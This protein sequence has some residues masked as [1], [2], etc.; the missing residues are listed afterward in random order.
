[1]VVGLKPDN[2]NGNVGL[3]PDNHNGN[4]GLKPDLRSC[5]S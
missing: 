4:V 3:K 1:V 2:H 5:T